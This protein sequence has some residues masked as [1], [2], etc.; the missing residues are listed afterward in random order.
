MGVRKKRHQLNNNLHSRNF[1]EKMSVHNTNKLYG[2][3]NINGRY[4]IYCVS[5]YMVCS[6]LKCQGKKIQV[7]KDCHKTHEHFIRK[8]KNYKYTETYT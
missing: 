5:M 8:K 4:V 2:P 7:L 3:L 6:V 1:E